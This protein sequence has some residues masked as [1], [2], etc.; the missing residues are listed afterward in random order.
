MA[1]SL[2]RRADWPAARRFSEELLSLPESGL[3][4]RVTHLSLLLEMK[5]ADFQP[6]LVS[7][8]QACAT[9]AIQAGQLAVWMAGHGRPGEAA[10]WLGQLSKSMQIQLPAALALAWCLADG[11]Q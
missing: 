1:A 9:N 6:F 8:Q 4:D 2:G 3:D 10:D 5:S 7:L 11:K